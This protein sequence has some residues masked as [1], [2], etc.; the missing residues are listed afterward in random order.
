MVI[1]GLGNPG[2]KYEGT[3]HNVGF[4][5][6][7][8]FVREHNGSWAKKREFEADVATI[9]R[10]GRRILLVKPKTYVNESGRAV[11]AVCRYYRIEPTGLVVVYDEVNLELGHLRISTGGSAG[12]HNGVRSLIRHLG[13]DFLRFRI[14]IGP[15]APAGITLSDFV[16]GKFSR[17]QKELLESKEKEFLEA[18][19][20]LIDSGANSAMNQVNQKQ[21]IQNEPNESEL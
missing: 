14:G 12:G 21:K 17:E 16:L 6:V 19:H 10:D 13:P 5:L 3:R 2:K 8:A 18:L 20:L 9:E 1:A 7:D 4:D 11:G 15:R